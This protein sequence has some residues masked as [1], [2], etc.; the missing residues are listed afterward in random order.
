M[1]MVAQ[2]VA[3]TLAGKLV[4][5]A[6]S[7]M[8][9]AG[10]EGGPATARYFHALVSG[11]ADGLAVGTHTGR[12]DRLSADARQ[13][14]LVIARSVTSLVVVGVPPAARGE[15]PVAWAATA[16]REGCTA[17]LVFPPRDTSPASVL[18]YYDALWDSSGLPLVVFD[19]YSRPYPLGTLQ[20]L[21]EHPAVAA[22]KPARLHDAIACQEGITAARQ[23]GRCVLTGE[24]RMFGPS[25]M[26]GAQGALVG[27]SAANVGVSAA[28]LAAHRAG[29]A[30]QFLRASALVDRFA[31]VTFR[32]PLDGYVQ[33]MLWVAADEGLLPPEFAVDPYRPAAMSDDE[34]PEV[35]AVARE[36][37]L[38]ARGF[39]AAGAVGATTA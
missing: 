1:H 23:R 7:P 29:A 16:A 32:A 8:T 28:L 33:R 25:L 36:T 34:R 12:G 15:D 30:T 24:D 22:F 2:E 19:L 14:L 6:T 31:S 10:V 35:V 17:L 3:R 9:T 27:I 39:G 38:G 11:G 20:R 21:L 4:A 18:E 13:R 26:W 37:R 5:A